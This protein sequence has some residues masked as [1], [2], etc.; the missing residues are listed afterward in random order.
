MLT[1]ITPQRCSPEALVLLHDGL[2]RTAPTVGFCLD[3]EHGIRGTTKGIFCCLRSRT[4]GDVPSRRRLL[5]HCAHASTIS[6]EQRVG[7]LLRSR[8]DLRHEVITRRQGGIHD[9]SGRLSAFQ[10]LLCES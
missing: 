5:H 4:L 7:V 3:G 6:S 9:G 10:P 1:A 2:T 8:N